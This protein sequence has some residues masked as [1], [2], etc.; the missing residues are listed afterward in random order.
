MLR[1]LITGM[2]LITGLLIK[3]EKKNRVKWNAILLQEVS[4]IIL[5]K[6]SL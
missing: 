6:M 4:E 1:L 5:P 2:L 3:R